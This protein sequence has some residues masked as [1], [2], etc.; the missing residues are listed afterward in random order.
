MQIIVA[1]QV[2]AFR[3]FG[4]GKENTVRQLTQLTFK[5]YFSALAIGPFSVKDFIDFMDGN[6]GGKSILGITRNPVGLEPIEILTAAFG[7]GPMTSSER[8]RFIEKEK[9]RVAPRSH[10]LTRATLEFKQTDNPTIADPTPGSQ[11]TPIIMQGTAS[12]AHERP[13]GR[14]GDQL[15]KR[16]DAILSWHI[17]HTFLE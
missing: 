15:P 6:I 4:K 2:A 12:I 13:A 16:I 17:N 5:R 8:G 10:D 7:A 3:T 1:K 11:H 9:F 14:R